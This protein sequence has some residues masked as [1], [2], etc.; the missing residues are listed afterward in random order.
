[1]T[2]AESTKESARQWID[3]NTS[4]LSEFHHRIWDHAEP[5]WREYRSAHD[6][7]QLLRDEGFD[8]EEGSG[9][10]PTAF[11]ATWGSGNPVIGSYAEYDAVPGN[12]Q[13][14]VAYQ[15]PR[16]GMHPWAPGHT[17]PHSA[18]GLGA[19]TGI[20]AAKHIM[21]RRGLRGTL[22]FFG[23]PA[24][25]VCGSKPVHAAKGYFDGMDAAISYHPWFSNT[26]IWDTHCGSYWSCVF[27]FECT[28]PRSWVDPALLAHPGH[29][30]AV[31]R[32]PGALDAVCL[33]YTLAK[34]TKENMYPHTGSWIL[35][36]FLMV[37]G[38]ATADNLSPRIAQI[39]YAWRGPNL[40][41]QQ[42]IYS[43]LEG[44]AR[45]AAQST[46]CTVSVRWVTKTRVGL[47][48]HV[49]AD[50]TYRNLEMVGPPAFPEEART[51]AREIQRNIGVEPL[52]NPFTEKCQTLQEPQ[53]EEMEVRYGLPAWQTNFTS[54][55]YVDYTWHAPTVR[56][57]TGKPIVRGAEN[58]A[59]WAN[60]ALN[61]FP[62]AID[63]TWLTAGKAIAGTIVDLLTDDEIIAEAKREF[64]E[65]TGG[66][67]GGDKWVAP[68]LP[69]DFEPPIDLP[70]PEYIETARG[71]EYHLPTT[72]SFGMCLD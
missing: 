9:G 42:Q 48:N 15:K 41:I 45:Q 65:R 64:D 46:N 23:E 67:I 1:M 6:Y 25:K 35:N 58:W 8:V 51:F 24:E 4:R 13:E 3:Q 68:L 70:W 37:G 32:S 44:L 34:Y 69:P 31:P 29:P 56:L 2:D 57:Y 5:A 27:T 43:V 53:Q 72:T 18:L 61:G 59:H 55:D 16:E 39:Q 19:L 66:G 17:D 10:M 71:R 54:D 11:M 36:E 28:E 22:R 20:L 40:G 52:E 62:P 49:M 33:M 47:P 38:Q 50:V 21:E 60:S 12:S 30:H 14:P 26:T 63:P 7:V